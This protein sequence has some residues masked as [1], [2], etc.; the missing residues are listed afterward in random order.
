MQS[1]RPNLG[2]PPH[3]KTCF[4]SAGRR[5]FDGV[6]TERQHPRYAHTAAITLH[7]REHKFEGRTHNVSKGGLCADL[8]EA[9]PV[10]TELQVDLQLVFED[11]SQSEPLRIP[12][13]VVWCTALDEGYQ[14]GLAFK[15]LDAELTKYLGM[16]LRFLDTEIRVKNDKTRASTVDEKFG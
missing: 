15:P 9:I 5:R 6:S 7:G 1:N 11:E 12:A 4:A 13:R 8:A 3:G 16:F 14:V 10:G 2:Q